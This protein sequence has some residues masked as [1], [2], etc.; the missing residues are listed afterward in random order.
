MS[1]AGPATA[2]PAGVR[3]PGIATAKTEFSPSG[4]QISP[5][6]ARN[7]PVN[8]TLAGGQDLARSYKTLDSNTQQMIS[9]HPLVRGGFLSPEAAMNIIHYDKQPGEQLSSAV[10]RTF[11]QEA[12][13]S[14]QPAAT[15]G[16]LPA[17]AARRE[18]SMRPTPVVPAPVTAATGVG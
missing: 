3:T 5:T 8:P 9:N 16:S 12:Q 7:T 14:M 11:A 15:Q 13:K 6:S 10:G 2:A 18:R 17:W 1:G 4:T